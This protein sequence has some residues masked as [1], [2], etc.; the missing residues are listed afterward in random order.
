VVVDTGDTDVVV[1]RVTSQRPHA[2]FDVE[3]EDW[4]LAGLLLPSIAHVHKLATIE[5]AQ[6]ERR[7]GELA[8]GD[9]AKVLSAIRA[10]WSLGP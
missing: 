5:K 8:A 1:A 6:V 7:L 3:I 2:P 9:W 4:R 10:M